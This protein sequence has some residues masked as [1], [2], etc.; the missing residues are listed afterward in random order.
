MQAIHRGS[1]IRQIAREWVYRNKDGG[2]TKTV[3]SAIAGK[4]MLHANFTTVSS[5]ETRANFRLK[6]KIAGIGNSA[7]LLLRS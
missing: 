7:F 5:T 3:R 2:H 4:P 1:C 6:F